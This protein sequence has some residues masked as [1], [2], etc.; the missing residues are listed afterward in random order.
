MEPSFLRVPPSVVRTTTRTV[1]PSMATDSNVER[2]ASVS[3]AAVVCRQPPVHRAK[4]PLLAVRVDESDIGGGDRRE[5][6]RV[7]ALHGG[8]EARVLRFDALLQGGEVVGGDASRDRGCKTRQE[9]DCQRSD[10][11]PPIGCRCAGQGCPV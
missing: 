9:G 10:H 1:P 4:V 5:G 11:D 2:I 6:R 3:R 8:I 7:L